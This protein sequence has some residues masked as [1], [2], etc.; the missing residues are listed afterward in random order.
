[1]KRIYL[2]DCPGVV[3]ASDDSETDIVLKGVVSFRRISGMPECEQNQEN[4]IVYC[5]C[6]Q[7][8]VEN[9]KNPEEHIGAVLER[10]QKDSLQRTYGLEAWTDPSD[11]LSQL[12]HRSGRL[13]KV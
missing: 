10:V 11:F 12:S 6:N 13:L 7:V 3:Y 8:R 2:I 9:L 1:M 4:L 5:F